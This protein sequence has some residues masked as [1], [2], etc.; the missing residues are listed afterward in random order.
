MFRIVFWKEY[1]DLPVS[2]SVGDQ[3]SVSCEITSQHKTD[4]QGNSY[5]QVRIKGWAIRPVFKGEYVSDKLMAQH[6][7]DLNGVNQAIGNM[8][9]PQEAIKDIPI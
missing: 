6:N 7:P 1:I 3:V 4:S 2:F 5:T 8:P 9:L